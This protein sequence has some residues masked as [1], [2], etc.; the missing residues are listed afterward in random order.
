MPI[1]FFHPD[2]EH[3]YLSNFSDHSFELDGKTWRTVEHYYQAQKFAGTTHAEK[4]RQARTPRQAKALGQTRDL[5][6]RADWHAVKF[7][8]M[9]RA[10]RKKF[11]T[12]PNIR[13]QLLATGD[14]ALI[15]NAPNDFVWGCGYDGSGQNQ[16]GKILMALRD[17]Y[18]LKMD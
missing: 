15:E 2:G 7:D 16:M 14:E 5:P 10:V 12:H 4:I 13:A 3:G 9:R 18:R 11:D 6:L 8:I 17:R 1:K